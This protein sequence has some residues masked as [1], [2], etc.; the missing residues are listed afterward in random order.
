MKNGGNKITNLSDGERGV[1][2]TQELR[3]IKFKMQRVQLR[4]KDLHR[5]LIITFKNDTKRCR[6]FTR[7]F[8]GID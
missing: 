5:S 6:F 2:G 8:T 3:F 7:G 1:C 4:V